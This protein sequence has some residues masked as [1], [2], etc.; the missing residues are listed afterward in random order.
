MLQSKPFTD[1]FNFSCSSSFI[2]NIYDFKLFGC[3]LM[4]F[5]YVLGG[6]HAGKNSFCCC[7]QR[8][9]GLKSS[10]YC[11]TEKKVQ[12]LPFRLNMTFREFVSQGTPADQE[13]SID[14][15]GVTGGCSSIFLVITAKRVFSAYKRECRCKKVE[16]SSQV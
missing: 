4:G 8:Y 7:L 9:Q 5:K 15:E 12:Y 14:P 2:C 6:P 10:G 1:L 3:I 16:F 11:V 13:G